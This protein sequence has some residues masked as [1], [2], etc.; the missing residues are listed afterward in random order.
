MPAPVASVAANSKDAAL[1]VLDKRRETLEQGGAGLRPV[2]SRRNYRLPLLVK[3]YKPAGVMGTMKNMRAKGVEDLRSVVVMAGDQFELDLYHPV[4]RLSTKM[5]GL[6][7]WS[8]SGRL[9][10]QLTDPARGIVHDF[11]AEVYGVVEEERLREQLRGGVGIG[12]SGF[13][14]T[15]YADVREAK[16]V[17]DAPL[18][19]P[20]S[21]V[22]IATRDGRSKVRQMLAACGHKVVSIKRTRVGF[23]S[24]DGLEEGGLMAATEEEEEWA[25]GLAGMF[26]SEYP[27]GYLPPARLREL[28]DR[29]DLFAA[30]LGLDKGAS[31]AIRQV[32]PEAAINIMQELEDQGDS[33]RN[34]SAWVCKTVQMSE[35]N[36]DGG[37]ASR[38]GK[39]TLKALQGGGSVRLRRL[40]GGKSTTNPMELDRLALLEGGQD[41]EFEL[42]QPAET[43]PTDDEDWLS[44]EERMSM[45][46]D[47]EWLSP[48]EKRA[49]EEFDAEFKR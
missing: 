49:L 10:R 26:E 3:Y 33:V 23:L 12:Y 48:S 1:L 29:R 30:E 44:P 4:G 9:T 24:V 15:F 35:W 19:D 22:V 31:E 21:R 25:C 34:R 16:M 2:P 32:P 46:N 7:L 39:R 45:D 13:E 28:Q 47:S 36:V 38:K 5:S 27:A 42:L 40:P 17:R 11:E 37:A 18:Q 8:R 20:R 6:L 41:E 14:T 43:M